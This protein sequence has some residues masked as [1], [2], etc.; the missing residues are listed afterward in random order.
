M[1]SLNLHPEVH[2]WLNDRHLEKSIWRHNSA[3]NSPI[4]TK[5]GKQMENDM[6]ITT[7]T[8][9]TSKSKPELQF[10]YG[11]R[12]FSQTGSSFISAGDRDISLKFGMGIEFYLLKQMPSV[13]MNQK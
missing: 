10:Q 2:F 5:F 6:P 11:G 8:A 13:N 4:T 1:Q 3:S 7:H 12:P 9:C